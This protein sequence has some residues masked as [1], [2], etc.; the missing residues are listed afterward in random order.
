MIQSASVVDANGDDVGH[1][2]VITVAA[3]KL[4]IT[5]DQYIAFED[6]GGGPEGGEELPVSDDDTYEAQK[7]A[8]RALKLVG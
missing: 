3:G 4:E 6:E 8:T 5:L 1:V 7:D 2:A